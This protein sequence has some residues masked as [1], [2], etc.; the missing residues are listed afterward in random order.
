MSYGNLSKKICS[1]DF[2]NAWL[3]N[4]IYIM[5]L[6]EHDPLVHDIVY[7]IT[8]IKVKHEPDIEL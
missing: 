5:I 7:N 8:M 1:S 2:M 4:T 3:P 6:L